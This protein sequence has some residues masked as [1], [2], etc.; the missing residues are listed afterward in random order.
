MIKHIV[1]WKLKDFADG[2]DAHANALEI[3]SRL[4]ALVGVVPGILRLEV[5]I[6]VSRTP[7]SADVALYSE[8]ADVAA[9]DVYANHPAHVAVADWLAEVRESRTVV[10]YE[11]A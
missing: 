6:D 4:E 5:G 1:F 7:A 2:R 3:Q 8:F 9:L 11:T 10:D